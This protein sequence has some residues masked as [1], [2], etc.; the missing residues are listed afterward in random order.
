[1]GGLGNAAMAGEIYFQSKES[2][3]EKI[4]L[5][6]AREFFESQGYERVSLPFPFQLVDRVDAKQEEGL[7]SLR[8]GYLN[9][10]GGLAGAELVDRS[11]AVLLPIDFPQNV[12][13]DFLAAFELEKILDEIQVSI[14]EIATQGAKS[15][16]IEAFELIRSTLP[17]IEADQALEILKRSS[18]PNA[19]SLSSS[20]FPGSLNAYRAVRYADKIFWRCNQVAARQSSC[21]QQHLRKELWDE[22]REE[23]NRKSKE[24]FSRS[25][26]EKTQEAALA[27]LQEAF[28]LNPENLSLSLEISRG[29]KKRAGSPDQNPERW[30]QATYYA[31]ISNESAE[32]LERG[33]LGVSRLEN[34]RRWPSWSRDEPNHFRLLEIYRRLGNLLARASLSPSAETPVLNSFRSQDE[35]EQMAAALFSLHRASV[36]G[37][38]L[39][40][41]RDRSSKASDWA[42][43][44]IFLST[45]ADNSLKRRLLRAMLLT[46]TE[47][48]DFGLAQLEKWLS[49]QP[50]Q[51]SHVLLVEVFPQASKQTQQLLLGLFERSKASETHFQTWAGSLG[52]LFFSELRGLSQENQEA[53]FQVF[54]RAVQRSIPEALASTAPDQVFDVEAYL[55]SQDFIDS[56]PVS[57]RHQASQ[58][59]RNLNKTTP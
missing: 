42:S 50:T 59:F 18:S 45:H 53:F 27:Y 12:E 30:L 11:V 9:S 10:F 22:L 16:L 57:V 26:E 28:L 15:A 44:Q 37:R 33:E 31:S 56:L 25:G 3:S 54:R 32:S 23:L 51:D 58:Y 34:N 49:T 40:N 2:T 41:L 46:E 47:L 48:R 21:V 43:K 29:L 20:D 39:L 55:R 35:V 8:I 7:K 19:L 36:G 5:P 6:Q 13:A 17:Q 52:P 4:G 24:A 1:M 38:A 14:P